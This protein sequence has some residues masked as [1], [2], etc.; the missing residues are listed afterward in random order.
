MERGRWL[1]LSFLYFVTGSVTS[2]R[3]ANRRD[4]NG[5]LL[6]RFPM[7]E[8]P[9]RLRAGEFVGRHR[10]LLARRDFPGVISVGERIGDVSL[11][12]SE[13][14]HREASLEG[15]SC[16]ARHLGKSFRAEC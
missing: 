4:V 7:W 1:F 14:H 13:L 3:V 15:R 2:F 9:C 8:L 12:E 10:T 16:S 5:R 6:W 11:V